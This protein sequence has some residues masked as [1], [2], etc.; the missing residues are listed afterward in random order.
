M[1]LSEIDRNLLDR[2]LGRKPR[3]WEDFVDR[4]VGLVMHVIGHTAQARSI[5]LTKEDR[6]D[7]AAD[8][9]LAIVRDDFAV[10]RHFRQQSSLATY[11]AVVARRVV[12]RELLKRKVQPAPLLRADDV[13]DDTVVEPIERI[14]D[15]DEVERLLD[16]LSAQ[17][18]EA[19]RQY[20]LG[21]KSY[22]EISAAL[23]IA[24]NS[25]GPLLS[26]ARARMRSAGVD[27]AGS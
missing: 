14:G 11:L 5:R 10:L 1:A 9:F 22:G 25:I 20:H 13:A 23:G 16:D 12:V 21:G 15:R 6:E 24:E 26:R 17:E 8:V 4:F 18:A 7:L 27:T 19:V 2:C 3:S